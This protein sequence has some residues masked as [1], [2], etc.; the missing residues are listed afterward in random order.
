[1][2]QNSKDR[3]MNKH[4]IRLAGF[5]AMVLAVMAVLAGPALAQQP[6]PAALATAKELVVAKGGNQMFEPVVMG[7]IEQTKAALLQTNPQLSKDLNDVSQTLRAEYGPRT[8]DIINE[9]AKQYA[10]RFTEAELKD[11]VT[12]YKAPLGQKMLAQE[13]QVLEA[14]FQFVQQWGPRVAEDLMNRFRAEMKK[15]GHNL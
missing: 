2:S 14:T 13:P 5:A 8:G 3:P 4:L 1:M 10:L 12:F 6:T 15:K 11:L 9:A 7:M